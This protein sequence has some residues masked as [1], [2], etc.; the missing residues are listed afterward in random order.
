MSRFSPEKT[1]RGAA[2]VY[3]WSIRRVMFT[4]GAVAVT[5]TPLALWMPLW[6]VLGAIP[7]VLAALAIPRCR[8]SAWGVCCVAAA[9]FLCVTA[10]YRWIYVTPMERAVG[11]T[12]TLTAQIVESPSGGQMVTVRVITA[13]HIPADRLVLLYLPDQLASACGDEVTVA[14]EL[15]ALNGTQAYRRAQGIHLCA[16]PARFDEISIDSAG[17]ADSGLERLRRTLTETVRRALPGDEGAVMAAMCFGER[18]GVD[19][20][21]TTVFSRSG[22]SHLLVV[23]GLHLSTVAGA[24]LLLLSWCGRR[25]AAALAMPAVLGFM[26]LVGDTPSVI[27]AGVMV[28][29]FLAGRLTRQR[30]DGLNSLGLAATLLV[31]YNPYFVYSASFQLSFAATFGVLAIAPRLYRGADAPVERTG[32][33]M[34]WH[35]LKSGVQNGTALCIGATLPTLPFVCYYFDGFPLAALPANLLAV[36]AGSG[37]LLLGWGGTVLSL[38]PL[39]RPVGD[40]FLMLAGVLVRYLQG[41]ATA[42]NADGLFV[43]VETRWLLLLV[44]GVCLLFIVGLLT[45][46]SIRRIIGVVGVLA[47]LVLSVGCPLTA[48]LLRVTVTP[49]ASGAVLTI[50]QGGHTA[51]CVTDGASLKEAKWAAGAQDPECL[52]VGDGAQQNVGDLAYLPKGTAIY[53]AADDG[54]IKGA[55]YTVIPLAEGE[56]MPLWGGYTVTVTAHGC[57]RLDGGEAPLWI[58][59]D[60]AAVPPESAGIVLYAGQVPAVP[61]EVACVAAGERLQAEE[62]SGYALVINENDKTLTLRKTGEWSVLPWL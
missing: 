17:A 53:C 2:E 57:W 27:R 19:R 35:K 34:V 60:V 4:V 20:S 52:L 3:T 44:T 25:R 1:S 7:L 54:W 46:L 14:V 13:E 42:F 31:L 8:L 49:T 21:W 28:L 41:V 10:S 18:S 11:Q 58:C 16:F 48:S 50:R 24:V 45:H 55:P 62:L 38:S 39:T 33:A 26:W 12:D 22:I 59:T 43:P 61:P 30:A 23:S 40:G 6:A 5:V 47:V 37:A 56:S 32:W 36:P 51:L 9:L 15:R 29:V